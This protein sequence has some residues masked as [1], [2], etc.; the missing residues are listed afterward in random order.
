MARLT[1]GTTSSAGAD[2]MPATPTQGMG[3]G[4]GVSWATAADILWCQDRHQT[5]GCLLFPPKQQLQGQAEPQP[6][7]G[8]EQGPAE[9]YPPSPEALVQVQGKAKAPL[10]WKQEKPCQSYPHLGN[11]YG[12][13]GRLGHSCLGTGTHRGRGE[14]SEKKHTSLCPFS[15]MTNSL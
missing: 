11:W 14:G 9:P 8:L 5:A 6:A 3:T 4:A 2:R 1:L 12:C 10:P 7:W 13:R 15:S